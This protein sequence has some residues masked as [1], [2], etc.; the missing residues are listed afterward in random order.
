[1]IEGR[2]EG[3]IRAAGRTELKKTAVVLGDIYTQRFSIEEG[4][5]LKGKVEV[6]RDGASAN[7]T[8]ATKAS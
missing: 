1:M 2:G 7:D 8:A 3:N 4:A 6:H 5:Y